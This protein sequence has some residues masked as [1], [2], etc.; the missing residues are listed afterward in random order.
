MRF[1][2]NFVVMAVSCGCMLQ[3]QVSG[4]GPVDPATL[5]F[6]DETDDLTLQWARET[7]QAYLSMHGLSY[8]ENALSLRRFARQELRDDIRSFAWFRMAALI[9][10]AAT[11]GFDRLVIEVA[12]PAGDVDPL[13]GGVPTGR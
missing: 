12:D 2:R 4:P 10:Q 11:L 3:A 13:L 6:P 8:E 9:D 7:V 5:I 1:L